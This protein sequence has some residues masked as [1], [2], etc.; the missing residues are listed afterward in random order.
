[1][2]TLNQARST[3]TERDYLKY[4]LRKNS[5]F[6]IFMKPTVDKNRDLAFFCDNFNTKKFNII[7]VIAVYD[8]TW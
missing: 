2:V 3:F 4:C 5:Q 7:K 1:M 6:P 8:T